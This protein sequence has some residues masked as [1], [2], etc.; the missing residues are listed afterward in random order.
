[1]KMILYA[2]IWPLHNQLEV[3][4]QCSYWVQGQI[5]IIHFDYKTISNSRYKKE[6]LQKPRNIYSFVWT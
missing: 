1:M 6:A 3:K 2:Q 4:I 5:Q